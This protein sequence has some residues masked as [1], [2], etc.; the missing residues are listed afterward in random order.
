MSQAIKGKTM[1]HFLGAFILL[2]SMLLSQV[3]SAG[4]GDTLGAALDSDTPLINDLKYLTD[5]IG[6]RPMGSKANERAVDWISG[7]LRDAGLN[8]KTP[9]FNLPRNWV[10]GQARATITSGSFSFEPTFVPRVYSAST[11]GDVTAPIVDIGLGTEDDFA[12]AGE[13]ISGA[14]VLVHTPVLTDE[15]GLA[16]LFSEYIQGYHAKA[17]AATAGA[18][19]V[20]YV[21]SRPKGLMMRH[22]SVKAFENTLITATVDR[23]NGLRIQR[24]IRGGET[25]SMTANIKALDTKGGT[26]RNVIAEIRGSERPDE[27]VIIGA[28][29]DSH[30]LGTGALDNGTNTSIVMD[31]ARQIKASG[32]KPKRTIR[33]ALWNGEEYGM[34]G[35]G[36][37]VAAHMAEMDNHIVSITHDIGGGRITGYFVNGGAGLIEETNLAMDVINARGPFANIAA[38]LVGTDNYDF[39]M[40][41]VPNLIANQEDATYASNYHAQSDTFDKVDLT[42][43]KKNAVIA[44]HTVLHFANSDWRGTRATAA[45]ISAMVDANKLHPSMDS[46]GLLDAWIRGDR[47]LNPNPAD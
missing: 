2:G 41:G 28:H 9:I 8:V 10:A 13:T 32:I 37:Y 3:T 11:N 22:V 21:S 36:A 27:I 26:A 23:E 6:G 20:V 33:F 24:A 25:V 12:R 46:F 35:S 15:A 4:D 1:R 7:R 18:I 16:G 44:G 30:D 34:L 5:T 29:M 39:M 31:I 45:E 47:G 17:R 38:P 14:F 42:Q 43:L 19:G 40:Y